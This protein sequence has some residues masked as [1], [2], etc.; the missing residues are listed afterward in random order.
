MAQEFH[1]I[2]AD[3][4]W[5]TTNN[6]LFHLALKSVLFLKWRQK[7]EGVEFAQSC[8]E[9][10]FPTPS[11]APREILGLWLAYF[12]VA[13]AVPLP[14]T[15]SPHSPWAL[16]LLWK[17]QSTMNLEP[18]T[19][20]NS[21]THDLWW[22]TQTQCRHSAK[23]LQH[24]RSTARQLLKGRM[25]TASLGCLT[26]TL[27]CRKLGW[28]SVVLFIY[29]FAQRADPGC[30]ITGFQTGL[31]A[32]PRCGLQLSAVPCTLVLQER[33]LPLPHP[34]LLIWHCRI[35][36]PLSCSDPQRI[37]SFF[38]LDPW[39]CLQTT[40]HF[41]H[42]VPK[43]GEKPLKAEWQKD[44]HRSYWGSAAHGDK[45]L[46]T[47]KGPI[48]PTQRHSRAQISLQEAQALTSMMLSLSTL[49]PTW[50]SADVSWYKS[51]G[52]PEV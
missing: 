36:L 24:P 8:E 26:R 18:G 27:N 16:S 9:D 41:L 15:H 30:A 7:Q 39:C 19:D 51:P 10:K 49:E 52:R 28:L 1:T 13:R 50:Y 17:S 5:T 3:S 33:V 32:A 35:A 43:M 42:D 2:L 34:H 4:L 44:T 47:A 14:A 22:T 48:Y 45:T 25:R 6:C 20:S 40:Q 31:W 21:K 23:Q 38:Q 37:T 29:Y 46:L 12:E 11:W